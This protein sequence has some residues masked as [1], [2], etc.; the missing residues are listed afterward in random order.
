ML[1][2]KKIEKATPVE[3]TGQII[4]ASPNGEFFFLYQGGKVIFVRLPKVKQNIDLFTVGSI[5]KVAGVTK[6]GG[7]SAKVMAEKVKKIGFDELP[8][9]AALRLNEHDS[10]MNDCDWV[11]CSGRLVSAREYQSAA[12]EK[13]AVLKFEIGNT[14]SDVRVALREGDWERIEELMFSRIRF[15]AVW[16]TQFNSSRQ[17]VGRIL[18]VN[19][20]DDLEL[21]PDVRVDST[22]KKIGELMREGDRSRVSAK[23][24]GVVTHISGSHIFVRD[25]SG[26]LKVRLRGDS[27]VQVGDYVQLD[28]YVLLDPIS[29][30]FLARD[31]S[32]FSSG[33]PP[34]PVLLNINDALISDWL[35]KSYSK[36]NQ[37]LVQ[38]DAVLVD[39]TKSFANTKFGPDQILLC[40]VG[41]HLFDARIPSDVV[42]PKNVVP[43]AKLRI[44]G[45]CDLI[46]DDSIAWR[47]MIRWF[48]IQAREGGVEVI[49]NAP[50]WTAKRLFWLLGATLS[51]AGLSLIWVLSLR[52]TVTKQTEVIS[53]KV[54]RESIHNERQRIARELHDTLLQG[55]VGMAIQIRGCF[56]GLDLGREKLTETICDPKTQKNDLFEA[57]NEEVDHAKKALTVV[58]EM[59]DRCSEES[60]SSVLY[61]RSGMA[62]RVRLAETL[63][64]VLEPFSKQPGISL[65]INVSGKERTLQQEVERNL[66]L[67]VKEIVTNAIKHASANTILVDLDYSGEGL[68]IDVSDDG[69]GFDATDS[70]P[71]GHFGLQGIRERIK[72]LGGVVEIESSIGH[73][74]AVVIKLSSTSDWEV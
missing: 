52:R 69:C 73:G 74:T 13:F 7:F 6:L 64:E 48:R 66:M 4:N 24:S 5:V 3:I 2:L 37:E 30:Q 45:I 34:E 9:T 17:I 18:Y 60:R 32:V 63:D 27:T 29:P 57:V 33:E 70:A 47:L 61:L 58:Q 20:V 8:E 42:L 21:N 15:N 53:E 16:G 71:V 68:V 23:T 19:S 14:V 50:W 62:R 46:K 11:R 65:S 12:G 43:G 55:L 54:E 31:V 10:T 39:R 51:L 56:R 25:D 59:L 1:S 67:A 22:L 49:E 40:R 41:E 36:L 38:I 44:T 28:G 26:S 35:N 72:A